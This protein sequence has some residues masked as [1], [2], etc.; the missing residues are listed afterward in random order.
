MKGSPKRT[1][2]SMRYVEDEGQPQTSESEASR[3]C[4]Q[5][6]KI[7]APARRKTK[8]GGI[9][10]QRPV[11]S[12]TFTSSEEEE[13]AAVKESKKKKQHKDPGTCNT[14]GKICSSSRRLKA[15]MKLVHGEAI[16]P[17]R[18]CSQGY[19]TPFNRKRHKVR[20]SGAPA[21]APACGLQKAFKKESEVKSEEVDVKVEGRRR[22]WM[23]GCR[24]FTGIFSK[25]RASTLAST[26]ASNSGQHLGP[27]PRARGRARARG[28][29]TS[30]SRGRPPRQRGNG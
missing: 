15:H 4:T 7:S 13:D 6:K 3:S 30:R 5:Q 17:C 19:K 8:A 1:R 21:R 22:R 10:R 9:V 2:T 29:G 16:F 24:G 20:C 27:A 25:T 11:I 28:Q 26:S 23:S 12:A 18:R 14:C